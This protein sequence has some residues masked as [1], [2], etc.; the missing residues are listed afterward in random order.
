MG[1]NPIVYSLYIFRIINFNWDSF[2]S[3][4]CLTACLLNLSSVLEG[5]ANLLLSL[6]HADGNL[7]QGV[8]NS[9][10]GSELHQLWGH[11]DAQLLCHAGYF[12]EVWLGAEGGRESVERGLSIHQ[13]LKLTCGVVVLDIAL[14]LSLLLSSLLVGLSDGLIHLCLH[15]R[16][17]QP[18]ILNTG[19]IIVPHLHEGFLEYVRVRAGNWHNWVSS[20][21]N[22]SRPGIASRGSDLDILSEHIRV[23]RWGW[24]VQGVR[25]WEDIGIDRRSA[26]AC[27]ALTGQGGSQIFSQQ[28]TNV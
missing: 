17:L 6:A 3:H 23:G 8:G 4:A 20:W 15:L 28:L 9:F 25:S 7:D 10:V 11:G 5:G 21:E 24:W 1:F 12:V 13:S 27:W 19:E 14:I 26:N 22:W 16:S 2:C 18:G